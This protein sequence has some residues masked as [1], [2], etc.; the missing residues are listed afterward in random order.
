MAA[1]GASTHPA[2]P[3]AM[4]I[5]LNAEY[6]KMAFRNNDYSFLKIIQ[7]T[8][9]ATT[10]GQGKVSP[11]LADA[12]SSSSVDPSD[13]NVLNNISVA[14]LGSLKS[15]S[16]DFTAQTTAMKD[17]KNPS[18]DDWTA[19]IKKNAADL[20]K[21]NDDAVD[22]AA[23]QA[24]AKINDMPGP[25]QDAAANIFITGTNIVNGFVQKIQVS[26]L[27]GVVGFSETSSHNFPSSLQCHANKNARISS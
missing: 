17:D 8:P 11:L 4:A 25:T 24:I 27:Q 16:D 12:D 10:D 7:A 26:S 20:K 21:K 1:N 22:A 3:W 5:K 15:H 2:K 19:K 14:T 9:R 13:Q 6:S 23:D 18:K